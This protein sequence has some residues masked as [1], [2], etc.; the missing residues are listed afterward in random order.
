MYLYINSGLNDL[1]SVSRI[2]RIMLC[3]KMIGSCSTIS[4]LIIFGGI[5]IARV[6]N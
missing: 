1:L 6:I 3:V 2:Y 5:W 4:G